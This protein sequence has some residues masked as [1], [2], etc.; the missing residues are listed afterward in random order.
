MKKI[1]V[2]L[3]SDT[4]TRPTAAMRMAMAEAEVGDDVLGD[5]PTTQ[6]L[7]HRVA[8][9]LDKE[10]A[11]FMPSGT[12]AN[13][14]AVRLH[15][16]PGDELLCEADCHI[17]T[18]EQGGSAQLSGVVARPVAG[19]RGVFGEAQVAE[20]PR[21]CDDHFTQTRL[22]C[23]ENTHNR[24]GGKVWP[25]AILRELLQ[26]AR[27]ARLRT[28]LDGARLFNASV[29]SGME[30]ARWAEG[31]DTVSVCFSKGLG[32]PVG[33]ALAGPL[34]LMTTA[35]RHRKLFGGGMRQSGMLAAAAL[36]ALENHVERLREDHANAGLFADLL[37]EA[38][39]CSLTYPDC[40]TNIVFFDIDPEVGSAAEVVAGLRDR[41]VL[42]LAESSQRIRALT[43][44]DVSEQQVRAAGEALQIVCDQLFARNHR[45]QSRQM[46]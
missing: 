46:T 9:L 42:V 6:L 28:H 22:V 30:V 13:Q 45:A 37:Q 39:G 18:H 35:R 10:A 34:E 31:F 3:R 38:A 15:C 11:V 4:V 44:L 5:D 14:V 25:E 8:E 12:M 40:Q 43:H 1:P 17:F 32:A 19:T 36:F 24:G 16:R 33:S 29:A 23:V 7:E 27:S 21:P 41:G 20:L 26:W 2:D